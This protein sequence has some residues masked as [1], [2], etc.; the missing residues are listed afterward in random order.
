MANLANILVVEGEA[1]QRFFERLCHRLDLATTVKV[2]SPR[3]L[4]RGTYNT[5]QGVFN[6]LPTL[7]QQLSDGTVLRL[8]VVV[9]AD[10]PP[11]GGFAATQALATRVLAP[12][13]YSQTTN[14][15]AGLVYE[16]GDGLADVGVWVMPDNQTDGML[17]DWAKQ[18]LHPKERALFAHALESVQTLPEPP[19]FKELQRSKAEVATWLAWQSRPGHGLDRAIDDCLLD[20]DSD[21]YRQLCAWLQQ[22]FPAKDQA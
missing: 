14:Q 4:Q 13:G 16:H 15:T 7:L 11:N 5:K 18:C 19:K 22:V 20:P 1:D 21:G 12:F 8:G 10:S 9:D 6:F 2:A 3:S 17:E